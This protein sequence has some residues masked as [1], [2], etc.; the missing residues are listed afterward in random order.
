MKKVTIF[1]FATFSLMLFA[2]CKTTGGSTT[3]G[4]GQGGSQ[5]DTTVFKP[6]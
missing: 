1:F 3:G 2:A 6:K 5:Q 4:S